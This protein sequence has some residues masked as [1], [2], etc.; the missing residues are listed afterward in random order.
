MRN[1]EPIFVP[2][3]YPQTNKIPEEVILPC[4][5]PPCYRMSLWIY[6]CWKTWRWQKAKRGMQTSIQDSEETQQLHCCTS[7]RMCHEWGVERCC[8]LVWVGTWSQDY[9]LLLMSSE[10]SISPHTPSG[11]FDWW[12]DQAGHR[13]RSRASARARKADS[14]EIFSPEIFQGVLLKRLPSCVFSDTWTLAVFACETTGLIQELY[15]TQSGTIKAPDS[16]R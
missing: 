12:R 13:P 8:A 5:K 14:L 10:I 9:W 3:K 11:S 1:S 16:Y 4:L 6:V 15:Y 2:K 7:Q